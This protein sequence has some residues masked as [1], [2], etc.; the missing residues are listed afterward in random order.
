MIRGMKVMK[1]SKKLQRQVKSPYNNK[2]YHRTVL[3][4]LALAITEGLLEVKKYLS[5][6]EFK[7]D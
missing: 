2:H 4:G 7:N 5:N 3:N 1:I 6:Q